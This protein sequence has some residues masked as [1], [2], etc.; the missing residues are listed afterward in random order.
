M[1]YT[2][3]KKSPSGLPAT[4]V[5]LAAVR[6]AFPG[7]WLFGAYYYHYRITFA[8]RTLTNKTHSS[9]VNQTRTLGCLCQ[10]YQVCGCDQNDDSRYVDDLIGTGAYGALNHSLITVT[11]FKGAPTILVNGSLPNGTTAAGWATG[12]RQALLEHASW[13]VVAGVLMYTVCFM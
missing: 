4:F 10:K 12:N 11:K 9:G 2:A 1:P 3:G 6:A 8:N 13:G 7:P 5:G